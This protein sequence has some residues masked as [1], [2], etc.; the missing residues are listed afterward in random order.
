M[1]I[2]RM[3]SLGST[4]IRAASTKSVTNISNGM[5]RTP[6]AYA[7]GFNSTV[8]PEESVDM[9]GINDRAKE[10]IRSLMKKGQKQSS[11]S[12]DLTQIL[13]E[14]DVGFSKTANGDGGSFSGTAVASSVDFYSP[15]M[16][17]D[18]LELPRSYAEE[19]R[20]YR[21][22]YD[23]DPLV[24]RAIDLKTFIPLSKITLGLPNSKDH[25][26]AQVILAF[27]TRMWK[28]LK[29]NEKLMWILHEYNLIGEVIP[30]FEWDDKENMWSKV[31]LLDPDLC[32]V[33]YNPYTDDTQVALIP[34]NSIKDAIA[35]LRGGGDDNDSSLANTLEELSDEAASDGSGESIELNTDPREKSFV[36]VFSRKR[37]P[38]LPGPG[39]S[40]LRRL[41]RTMLFR[42]KLRQAL[43]QI[44]SRHMTP[45]RLVWAE[46][47]NDDQLEDL[48]MQV[49]L[50]ITGPDHSIVTNYEVHWEEIT[51]EGRLFDATTIHDQTT[52]DMLVGLGMTK[53]LLTGEGTYGGGRITLQVLDTEYAMIRDLLIDMVDEL[54]RVVAE[55]NDFK[56]VDEDTGVEYLVYPQL[57]FSRMSLRDYA[58]MMDFLNGLYDKDIIDSDILLELANIDPVDIEMKKKEKVF[59][60][61]DS[62][63]SELKRAVYQEMVSK[64]V[65]STELVKRVVESMGLPYKDPDAQVD[66]TGEAADDGVEA[67]PEGDGGDDFGLGDMDMDM[68]EETPNESGGEEGGEDHPEELE[69][70][71]KPKEEHPAEKENHPEPAAKEAA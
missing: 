2:K 39:V 44:T 61:N 26:K 10:H 8:V 54:F 53:E 32:D 15:W 6:S 18:F 12:F 55:K 5:S 33:Q 4:P 20:W 56:E 37:S 50:A 11:Q 22:F 71:P 51:A 67:H 38:Y 49:D 46:D 40:I 34:D 68:G 43:T 19:R 1:K 70:Q 45:L 21:F 36:R 14:G 47:L 69:E 62:L 7:G 58:D 3:R 57:K 9:G 24:G 27:F 66:A 41:T 29:M 30:Y 42:D 25:K 35:D 52:D 31:L 16:S 63:F 60:I 17:T 65:D 48:R 59:T 23:Q 28:N 13:E 64:V